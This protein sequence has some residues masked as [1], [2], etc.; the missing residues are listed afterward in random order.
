MCQQVIGDD[1]RRTLILVQCSAGKF[2]NDT[3]FDS[4]T[5]CPQGTEQVPEVQPPGLSLSVETREQMARIA[6]KSVPPASLRLELG[7]SRKGRRTFVAD[8]LLGRLPE[9]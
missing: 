1:S 7:R 6:V 3:G 2:S 5:P 9:L 4:C 8:T